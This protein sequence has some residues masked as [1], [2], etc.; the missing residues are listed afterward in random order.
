[1][2]TYSSV[3]RVLFGFDFFDHDRSF[4]I[5]RKNVKLE[6]GDR[7]LAWS[8]PEGEV[9]TDGEND[10]AAQLI[11]PR[12]SPLTHDSL[13]VEESVDAMMFVGSE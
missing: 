10:E 13:E 8:D 5:L 12:M 3:S 7:K 1:M 6:D 4:L 9:L 2:G 11:P